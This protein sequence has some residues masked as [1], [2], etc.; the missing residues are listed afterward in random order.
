M[1]G[2]SHAEVHGLDEFTKL[3]DERADIDGRT[4]GLLTGKARLTVI[5]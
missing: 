5:M 3:L 1:Y 4:R 2:L